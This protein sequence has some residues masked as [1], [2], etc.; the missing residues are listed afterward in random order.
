MEKHRFKTK[1][2]VGGPL[3]PS[4]EKVTETASDLREDHVRCYQEI[5]A[6]CREIEELGGHPSTTVD[7]PDNV[8]FQKQAEDIYA[9]DAATFV[10]GIRQAAIDGELSASV[11]DGI[12]LAL[13]TPGYLESAALLGQQFYVVVGNM[14]DARLAARLV[15]FCDEIGSCN[16]AMVRF[17][18]RS[19][20]Y[21]AQRYLMNPWA[22]LEQAAVP[23]SFP[24]WYFRKKPPRGPDPDVES[25][26]MVW[27]HLLISVILGT[28]VE[29]LRFWHGYCASHPSAA[30]LSYSPPDHP[31]C[32]E[33]A[34]CA[35]IVAK[36]RLFEDLVKAGV[37]APA[38]D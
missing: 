15:K 16:P 7:H 2:S 6:L 35:F 27:G 30:G 37:I 14:G 33:R 18:A 32:S 28:Q 31:P 36:K 24:P 22:I 23:L 17:F 19:W 11:V 21:M 10:V 4:A 8:D 1:V 25:R 20:S 13:L 26:V 34:Q 38:S 3:V 5:Q 12:F 29:A 9:E